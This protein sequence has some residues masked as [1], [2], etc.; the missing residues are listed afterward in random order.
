MLSPIQDALSEGSKT[1]AMQEIKLL[2]QRVDAIHK[3]RNQP[4]GT[5]VARVYTVELESSVE[6]HAPH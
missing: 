2:Q 6:A 5:G 4:N 3:S 1:S